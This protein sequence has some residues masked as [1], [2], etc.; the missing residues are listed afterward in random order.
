MPM[1]SEASDFKGIYSW[2]NF[3]ALESILST[4]EPK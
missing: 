4:K 2:L 3:V 1:Y